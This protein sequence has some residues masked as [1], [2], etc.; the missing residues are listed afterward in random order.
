MH[1]VALIRKRIAHKQVS[2][3]VICKHAKLKTTLKVSPATANASLLHTAFMERP[4]AQIK[5]KYIMK[6]QITSSG[7]G[8]SSVLDVVR[9]LCCSFLCISLSVVF[10]IKQLYF[11]R[12]IHKAAAACWTSVIHLHTEKAWSYNT[13]IIPIYMY[14]RYSLNYTLL[15]ILID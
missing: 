13:D 14:L 7:P 5:H 11:R 6:C 10:K 2:F 1:P 9:S 4:S 8:T 12:K 15:F 3:Q